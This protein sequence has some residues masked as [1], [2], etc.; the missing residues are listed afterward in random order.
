MAVLAVAMT[1]SFHLRHPPSALERRMA[2]PLGVIFWLLVVAIL[3]IG[4][5]NYIKTVN[6]YSRKAAI[7]QTGWRTQLRCSP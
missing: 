2:M 6:M 7:V 4:L 3:L 5:G 1:V